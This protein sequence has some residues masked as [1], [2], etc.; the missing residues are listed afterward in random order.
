MEEQQ[1]MLSQAE[2]ELHIA[3]TELSVDQALRK[4]DR[5]VEQKS[6]TDI[7]KSKNKPRGRVLSEGSEFSEDIS[8]SEL[9][10]QAEEEGKFSL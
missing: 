6:V 7:I 8:E 10:S 1:C 2:S 5:I 4:Y 3:K 9:E